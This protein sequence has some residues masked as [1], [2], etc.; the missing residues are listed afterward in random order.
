MKEN[1]KNEFKTRL[2][3]V[4]CGM[5]CRCN[6]KKSKSYKNY[7]KRGIKV[8]K[9]WDNYQNF[10][11]WALS[12][13][14]DENAKR[15]QCTLDRI[16]VNGNYEPKNCRFVNNK[17]QCN[18]KRNNILITYKNETHTLKEWS[19]ITNINI[20]TLQQRYYYKWDIEKM[21]TLKPIK[22]RNQY[23]NI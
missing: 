3:Y 16:D 13:G 19:E 14:Y 9:E 12:N 20:G 5:R 18:N 21:L 22:G 6:Y 15:G 8:C 10:K 2:Y 1:K 11:E 7:G 17:F 4:W 23:K